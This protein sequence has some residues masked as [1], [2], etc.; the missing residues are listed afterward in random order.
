MPGPGRSVFMTE[1]LCRLQDGT[2]VW[3][4]QPGGVTYTS[5]WK[6]IDMGSFLPFP[7]TFDE[8]F[9]E[10]IHFRQ[11][12]NL[13]PIGEQMRTPP[14]PPSPPPQ[15]PTSTTHAPPT[16]HHLLPPILLPP[17]PNKIIKPP[18]PEKAT[19]TPDCVCVFVFVWMSHGVCL[20]DFLFVSNHIC[21]LNTILK[22]Y[23]FLL[24]GNVCLYTCV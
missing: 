10:T 19:R 14:H 20:F 23:E 18:Q 17:N 1:G 16:S 5:R 4:S 15:D 21:L 3:D 13:M 12:K 6:A 8:D 7:I 11:S 24:F 9:G 2:I 22:V